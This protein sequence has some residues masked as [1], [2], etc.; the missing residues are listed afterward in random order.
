MEA[1]REPVVQIF[2]TTLRDGEQSPGVSLGTEEKLEIAGYLARLQVDIIEAGFPI[3]SQGER[4]AVKKIAR[5]IKGPVIAALARTARGDIDAAWEAI[6]RAERPRIH[7]FIST[8]DLHLRH[9]LGM[10]PQEALEAAVESVR[11][12]RRLV[13]DVQF[14]AQD[15]TRSD[16]GFLVE[17]LTAAIKA[18]ATT[19]NVPDTVGYA[20]PG[21]YEAL[22]R[23]LSARV[24]NIDEAVLSAHTHDD[25]GL[26]VANALAAIEGG[27]RQIEC[28]INGI[29]ERAGNCALEEVVMGLHTRRDLVGITTRIQ[30]TALYRLSRLVA[31]LTGMTVSPNKAV[32]GANAFA[33]ES[34]IHQDGVLKERTTYEIMKPEDVGITQTRLVLGKH[35]GR[36]AFR[37]RLSE[38]GY[39]P[40]EEEM[41]QAFRRF[42]DLA[43]RKPYVSDEDI[44]AIVHAELSRAPEACRLDYFLVTS[45]N[46]AIPTATVR[47]SILGELHENSA[48]GN[49]PVDALFRAVDGAAGRTH[50]LID[51]NI[52]AV[53]GGTNALGE[54]TVRVEIDGGMYMG[55]GLSPDVVEASAHAYVNAINRYL[56]KTAAS[57]EVAAQTISDVSLES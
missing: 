8:S 27:A 47:L 16:T 44:E 42:K 7:L 11:Y 25:L 22:F 46:S 5:E 13:E 20:M 39:Q 43:D 2:D 31:N 45:G 53:T 18:G 34:G 32:I 17:I 26:A 9:M 38:L 41:K 40:D 54:V 28:T 4:A 19:V 6:R 37:D 3:T 23:E 30:T 36:H 10:S 35:S 55:R 21:E 56:E 49:G 52:H 14:S 12:A 15:A 24:P 1:A 51:Y 29:G 50:N 48:C 57:E 33:H